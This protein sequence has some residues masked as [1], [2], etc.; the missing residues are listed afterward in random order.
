MQVSLQILLLFLASTE[1]ATTGGLET[2]F[3]QDSVFGI[4]MDPKL[5]LGISVL[6]SLRTC[7]ALHIKAIS[8]EKIV[9]RTTTRLCVMLWGLFATGRRILS[10]LSFFA[11]SLGLLSIL[12]HHHAEQLPFRLRVQNARTVTPTDKIGLFG[13]TDSVLW[14][15]LDRWSYDDPDHPV[16]PPFSLYTGMTL[17]GTFW[18]F[19]G[20]SLVH[21]IVTLGIKIFTSEEFSKKQDYFKKFIHILEHLN[22][23]FPYSDWDLGDHSKEEY[24]RRYR[25][26][27]KEM[28]FTFICNF[29]F[30]AFMLIP[31]WYTGWQNFSK[32]CLK[33]NIYSKIYIFFSISD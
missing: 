22:I 32:I 13:M 8:N 19:I 10:I 31:L 26:T 3:N 33:C 18:A 2:V 9:F 29:I 27:N 20:I 25:N 28:A 1:T 30:S 17:K 23:N 11:P 15:E 16:P 12:H 21:M 7:I 4:P 5:V 6:F 14:S 24:K